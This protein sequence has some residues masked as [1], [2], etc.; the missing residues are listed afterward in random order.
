MPVPAWVHRRKRSNQKLRAAVLWGL[1]GNALMTPMDLAVMIGK[2][3]RHVCMA[4][5]DLMLRGAVEPVGNKYRRTVYDDTGSGSGDN[6]TNC[7]SWGGAL[8]TDA[9]TA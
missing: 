7:G 5:D 1:R 8:D 9:S 3:H 4:L 2:P 6:E